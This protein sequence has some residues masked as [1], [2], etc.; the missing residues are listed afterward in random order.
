M[1][2][3]KVVLL[4]L[5]TILSISWEEEEGF[6]TLAS[7]NTMVT[8]TVFCDQC[9]DGERGFLDYGLSGAKV[10]VACRGTDGTEV[11]YGEDETNWFGS[12]S[13]YFDGSPDLSGCYA[14]VVGGPS[15]CGAA[16]GPAQGLT[17][18]FRMF[19]MAMYVVEPLLSEPQVPAGFCPNAPS[20]PSPTPTPALPVPPP[21]PPLPLFEVSACPYGKWLMP[22]YQCYWR[23][24]NP[25]TRVAIAFGPVAAGRYGVEL[26]MWEALHGRGDLYRT[27]LREATA[28][29]LNSYNTLNFLYPTLSVFDLMNRALVG[30]PQDALTVALRF[31]MANSGAFGVET[32]GCNFTPC[33]S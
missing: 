12:Y 11:A 8:G 27:L 20:L 1:G 33:R 23:V 16:A 7:A 10:A 4:V 22:Q 24:V 18:L 29:L 30:S 2:R 32:V 9:Q 15:G 5:G 19:G 26:T 31:R 28:S 25:D 13:V 14:R 21:T 6:M 3:M 17:L